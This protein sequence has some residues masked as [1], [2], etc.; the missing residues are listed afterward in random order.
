MTK[1]RIKRMQSKASQDLKDPRK[2]GK[3]KA[4]KEKNQRNKAAEKSVSQ[5][6]PRPQRARLG[7][8]I[9]VLLL[10]LSLIVGAL[11]GAFGSGMAKYWVAKYIFR[12]QNAD[13]VIEETKHVTLEEDSGVIEAAHKAS[14]AVVSIVATSEIQDLFGNT[15]TQE[16]IGSG[17]I[18]TSDGMI[19]TNR[20]VVPSTKK[21]YKVLTYDGKSYDAKVTS[22]DPVNDIA[23]IKIDADDLP[24]LD[25]GDSDKI[26]V[27]QRVL[28]I[29]NALGEYQNTVTS[30]VISATGRTIIAGSGAQTEKLEDVIQTDAAINQGNS[31]G[32]LVNLEGQVVGIN[33][34]IDQ[35]GQLISFAIPGN[36]VKEALDSVL[37]HGRVIRPYLGVRYLEITKEIAGLNK[38]PVDKGALVY[39]Q[40]RDLL[41]VIPDSPAAKAGL[42][43]N[44]IITKVN[45]EEINQKN[46]LTKLIQKYSPGAEVE[47]T[48]MRDGKEM[49]LKVKLEEARS[50]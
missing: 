35:G 36:V 2:A 32:P 14:P 20:H 34:A 37:E 29:G 46:S 11:G 16:G 25:F 19:M 4:V 13:D 23:V 26:Q 40:S 44:D 31:G 18:V 12:D 21:A 47:L 3:K 6:Q 17:F 45:G 9:V 7:C 43:V 5:D 24:V 1:I 41:A 8:G 10:I 33:T 22:L 49:N 50:S 15:I 38:L 27:G 39:S 48:I 30:G 28:A 42:E